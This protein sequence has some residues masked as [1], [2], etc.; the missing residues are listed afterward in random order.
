MDFELSAASKRFEKESAKRKAAERARIERQRR[1]RE[2]ADHKRQEFEAQAE[3]ERKANLELAEKLRA[4]HDALLEKNK[5]V[6]TSQDLVPQLNLTA[7]A[8]GIRRRSDKI[9]LP[10]SFGASLMPQH[11]PS[12]HGPMFFELCCGSKVTHATLLDFEAPEGTV[13]LPPKVLRCLGLDASMYAAAGASAQAPLQPPPPESLPGAVSSKGGPVLPFGTPQQL[14]R[15]TV[16]YRQLKAGTY[17]K[18]QPVLSAF[19]R[20]LGDIKTAL[21]MELETHATLSEGDTVVVKSL[22]DG[23]AHELRVISL[24]PEPAVSIISTD[25]EV[26]IAPSVEAQEAHAQEEE[27][28]ARE[29]QAALRA[30]EERRRRE[31]EQAAAAEE[32]RA[33]AAAAREAALAALP[34]ESEESAT[35]VTVL[36]KLPTGERRTRRFERAQPA[37]A[38]FAFVD[39]LDLGGDGHLHA[40]YRL[41]SQFPRRVLERPAPGATELSVE[42]VGLTGKQEALFV[43]LVQ[44]GL[45]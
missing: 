43:E 2:A 12:K 4:R 8:K 20:D 42:A 7:Q 18:L 21:E 28:L 14:L 27:R 23:S 17:A 11:D 22:E 32:L 40:S 9:S 41:A 13:G 25:L 31:E 19:Q 35:T 33:A 30:E 39:S 5:G 6:W 37:H 45:E 15:V 24:L 29:R 44:A 3:A 16:V 36:I 1:E 26:D 34:A 10:R 38:L